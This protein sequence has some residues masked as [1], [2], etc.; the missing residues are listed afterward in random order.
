V[1]ENW[2]N[3][4]N[5]GKTYCKME[6][7]QIIGNMNKSQSHSLLWLKQPHLDLNIIAATVYGSRSRLHTR[8]LQDR[9][10]GRI[11]FQ[12]WEVEQLEKVRV[13][14]LQALRTLD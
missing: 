13:Q 12:K 8:K 14:L 5:C 11:A 3:I 6:V 10:A 2:H 7:V 4:F 9:L 1:P